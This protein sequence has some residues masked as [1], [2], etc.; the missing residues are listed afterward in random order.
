MFA[1]VLY[2]LFIYPMQSLLGVMLEWLYSFCGSYGISI[3]LLSLLVNVFLLKLTSLADKKAKAFSKLKNECDRKV[4][5]FKRVFRGAELQSYIRVLYRQKHFHPIFALQSL[6]GLALQIPFFLGVLFLLSDLEELQ[7]N[8]FLGFDLSCEDSLLFGINLLPLVMCFITIVSVFISFEAK[9][10]RIQG[11]VI[12]LIF[13]VLLYPMPSAL[14]LYWTCNVLFSFC[15]ILVLH[16]RGSILLIQTKDLIHRFFRYFSLKFSPKIQTKFNALF[17]PY[18][19]LDSQNYS[20]LRNT[21]IFAIINSC[22][23]IFLFSPLAIYSSDVRQFEAPQTYIVI[24]TLCGSC[25]LTSLVLVY[26]A[27]FLFHTRFLKILSIILST[28]LALGVLYT[29]I[30]SG[31]YGALDHLVLQNPTFLDRT[32]IQRY[33][34]FNISLIVAL[35]LVFVFLKRLIHIWKILCVVLVVMSLYFTYDIY[36]QR[37]DTQFLAQI[38]QNDSQNPQDSQDSQK[39]LLE[40]ELFSYS[41]AHKNIVILVLDMFSGSH[42]PYILEQFPEFKTMLDGFIFFPNSISTAHATI[43]SIASLIG[44]EHYTTYNMNARNVNLAKEMTKAFGEMGLNFAN[45]GYQVSYFLGETSEGSKPIVDY[46]E[47]KIFAI[48]N[49]GLYKDYYV[50]SRGIQNNALIQRKMFDTEVSLLVSLGVFRFTPEAYRKRIYKGGNWLISNKNNIFHFNAAINHASSFYAFTH[51]HNANATKPTFKYLHSVMTHVPYAMYYDNGKCSHFSNKKV[52]DEYPHNVKITKNWL[53]HYDTE[54]CAFVF[55][56]DY[57]DWLKNE[58]IYDNTQIF[59]VSD[60]GGD[61]SINIRKRADTIFLFKDFD[62]RGELKTDSRLMANYDMASIF[63]ENLPQGCPNVPRNILKHYPHNREVIYTLPH[64]WILAKH[65]PN[66]WIINEYWKIK[67][68]ITNK[69]NWQ[70]ITE[71]VKKGDL[72][73]TGSH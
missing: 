67:G 19:S 31:D 44:G 1:Q 66:E 68:E 38:T 52:F 73:I 41:K 35:V 33:L 3:I 46:A 6:G 50:R 14:V 61:A 51:I 36:Q 28:I 16:Y 30:L 25:V 23:M 29:F 71:E 58:G 26:G 55:L 17:T 43:P 57:I 24:A 13:L 63:C 11:I 59:I 60:H 62:T 5:E 7:G 15:R 18:A 40:D 34:I 32:R 4:K 39:A 69:E 9:G 70:D 2:H 45:N 56:R 42:M 20:I 53:Q 48:Q 12:A 22:L 49:G 27:S 65:K 10:E 54:S 37:Q 72:D 21:S 47:N 8:I 64:H